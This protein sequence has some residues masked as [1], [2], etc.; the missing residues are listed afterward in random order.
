MRHVLFFVLTFA[1]HALTL[2]QDPD[3]SSL[4]SK[5]KEPAKVATR[6]RRHTRTLPP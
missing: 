2:G 4:F 6:G 1:V 3:H 5:A